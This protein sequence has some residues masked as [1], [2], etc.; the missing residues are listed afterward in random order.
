MIKTLLAAAA[1]SAIGVAAPA[2]AQDTTAPSTTVFHINAENP[3]KCQ[4]TANNTAVTLANDSVSNSQGFANSA[5]G[6]AIASQ[7]TALNATAW[8]T[9]TRNSVVLTR[10]PLT[11]GDG[12][13]SGGFNQA[14]IYDV[15]VDLADAMRVDNTKPI[16]GTSDGAGNG[17]GAGAGSATPVN[18]FGPSGAGSS[19]TFTN[20]QGSSSNATTNS[21]PDLA[22]TS[23]PSDP[24]R[25][26]AGNYLGTVTLTIS[27]GA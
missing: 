13:Q 25:L 23:Y 16:E 2:F 15:A 17:P 20:E 26:V 14:V 19:L 1:V 8:C 12:S 6:Q 27:P 3:A 11:T 10:S 22:R 4:V 9:G 5:I 7:L 21:A 24:N 18:H